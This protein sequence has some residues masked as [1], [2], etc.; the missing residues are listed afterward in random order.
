MKGLFFT[1]M[2]LC[3]CSYAN[4]QTQSDTIYYNKNWSV[5]NNPAFATYYRILEKIDEN[6]PVARYRDFWMNGAVCGEG[7]YSVLDP[8]NGERFSFEGERVQYYQN[9]QL[10]FRKRYARGKLDGKYT[11]YASNGLVIKDCTYY[12]GRLH[13]IYT[14]FLD[15]G[16]FK[17]LEYENGYPKNNFYYMGT[18]SGQISRFRTSDNKIY[19]ETPKISDRKTMYLKGES[20]QYY[21]QNGLRVAISVS[22]VQQYGDFFKVNIMISNNSLEEIVFTPEY[23]LMAYTI[24]R[25]GKVFLEVFSANKYMTRVKSR[26]TLATAMTAIGEVARNQNAGYSASTTQTNQVYGGNINSYGVAAAAGAAVGTGGAA[27]GVGVGAYASNTSYIGAS[28]TTSTTVSYSALAEYQ[29]DILM[30]QKLDKY[31]EGLLNER[32]ALEKGYLETTTIYPGESISGY[33]MVKGKFSGYS[34]TSFLD[35]NNCKYEFNF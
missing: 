10:Q 29:Q 32:D 12:N 33:V 14:E 21:T 8:E 7:Q 6:T 22:R 17:Q 24:N 28:S 19:W 11:E 15:N 26:Q 1:I 9:G 13:G 5:T 31:A 3:I 20:W 30:E 23:D 35:I 16:N 25:K 2:A 18:P 4:S 34:I 27:V